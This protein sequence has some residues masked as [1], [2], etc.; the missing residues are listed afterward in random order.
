[1]KPQDPKVLSMVERVQERRKDVQGHHSHNENVLEPQTFT[2]QSFGE[3]KETISKVKR[4]P[5]EQEDMSTSDRSCEGSSPECVK[6]IYNA[7]PK[8]QII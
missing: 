2:L 3:A 8:H 7:T 5:T 1:M 4:P 6:N